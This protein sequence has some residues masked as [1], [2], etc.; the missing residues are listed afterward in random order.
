[1]TFLRPFPVV[2]IRGYFAPAGARI[3]LLSVRAPRSASITARC[4]GRHCP[5][6]TRS[7]G[8]PPVRL[9]VFERFLRAGTLLQ[10]RVVRAG[11]IGKYVSFLIRARRAPLRTD[12]CLVPGR[13][14]PVRC[15]A[16]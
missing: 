6:R 7:F 1:M 3:T 9:R 2:R 11:Q 13:R 15:E 8:A 5:I 14:A 16:T 4:V 10:I 12:R